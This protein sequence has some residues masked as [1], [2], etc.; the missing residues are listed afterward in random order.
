MAKLL[1]GLG[2]K[3]AAKQVDRQHYD[4]PPRHPEG[5]LR[6]PSEETGV[7]GQRHGTGGRQSQ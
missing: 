3:V 5:A 2:D 4:E 1:P 7:A 6:Q